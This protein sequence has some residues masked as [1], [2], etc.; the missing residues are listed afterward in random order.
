MDA[1]LITPQMMALAAQAQAANDA[2]SLS[3]NQPL[4]AP[5][6]KSK[7]SALGN[8][9]RAALVAIGAGMDVDS[10]R[11]SLHQPGLEEGNSW[12]YG[13]HPSLGRLVATKAAINLPLLWMMHKMAEKNPKLAMSLAAV[14]AAPQ[15]IAGGM[16]YSK[17]K[18]AKK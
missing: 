3:G 17:I 18:D 11:K 1:P 2:A 9:I 6:E 4:T 7:D 5:K 14:T 16:N 15:A 13:K 12:M 10:T 8:M